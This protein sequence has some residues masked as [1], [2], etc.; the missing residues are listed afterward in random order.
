MSSQENSQKV[1]DMILSIQV[2]TGMNN[3]GIAKMMGYNRSYISRILKE[4][5]PDSFIKRFEI[6]FAD[7][8]AKNRAN[9]VAKP[10]LTD[11]ALLKALLNDYIKLKAL[12]TKMKVEDIADE[13]E[14]ST[15]LILR[16]MMKYV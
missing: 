1:K 4:G 13:L 12:I 8:L 16:D 5:V 2:S 11:Q 15:K 7:E 14:Q 6:V 3:E 10:D 9:K